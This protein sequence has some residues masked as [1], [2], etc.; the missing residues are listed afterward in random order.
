GVTYNRDI[1]ASAPSNKVIVIHFTASQPAQ[2]T[3]T[4]SFTT[5]Q[6]ATYST[7]GNDLVMHASVTAIADVRYFATGLTN[8]VQYDARVRVLATGGSVTANGSSISVTNADDVT[9]LL[10]VASNVS[11]YNDLTANYPLI[12]SNNLAAAAAIGYPALRQAQ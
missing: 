7:T 1:F 12:C 2:I 10:A 3:F 5:P 6:T 8:L 4:C 9:L 11:N